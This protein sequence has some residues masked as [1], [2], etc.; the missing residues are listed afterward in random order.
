MGL[1]RIS[2]VLMMLISS[3]RVETDVKQEEY[4]R[5]KAPSFTDLNSFLV[6]V[7]F[8]KVGHTFKLPIVALIKSIAMHLCY[9]TIVALARLMMQTQSQKLS[10]QAVSRS[11]MA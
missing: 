10:T 2:T 6:E 5:V 3:D 7:E 8:Y 4:K 11:S 9:N 1:E